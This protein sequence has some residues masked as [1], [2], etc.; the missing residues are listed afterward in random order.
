MS[1]EWLIV[2]EQP[3]VLLAVL[4]VPACT[5]VRL[6]SQRLYTVHHLETCSYTASGWRVS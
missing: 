6:S 2:R 5:E 1:P 4:K 3:L